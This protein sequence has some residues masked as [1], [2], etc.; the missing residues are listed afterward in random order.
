VGECPK[1]VYMLNTVS[2]NSSQ[3]SVVAI[4]FACDSCS[5][6]DALRFDA[7][8]R[9]NEVLR[10]MRATRAISSAQLR[11]ALAR[12][13]GLHPGR[14]YVSVHPSAFFNWVVRGLRKTYGATGLRSGGLRID[15]TLDS[16]MQQIADGAL[17]KWLTSDTDPSGALVAIDPHSG[18]IRALATIVPGG[19]RLRFNL[20]TQSRRQAGSAF[21]TFTITAA[22]EHGIP[23]NSVWNGP[24]S[25]TIPNPRCFTGI[26]TPW[27][28]H[29]FADETAGTMTLLSALAHSVNTIFAQVALRV[30]P[31][32]IVDVAHRLGVRS[33]LKPV[34]S[35]T[36]GPEGVSPLELTAAFATLAAGG[37]RRDPQ[38][39]RR[40]T[41]AERAVLRLPSGARSRRR[42][43]DRGSGHVR[44]DRGNQGR[45]GRRRRSG[46]SRRRETGTAEHEKD[47]WFCGFVPQLAA[48]VWIGYPHSEQPMTSVDGFPPVVGGSVPTRIWHDFMVAALKGVPVIRFPTVP[49][50][51]LRVSGTRR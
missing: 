42:P 51:Q 3:S 19:R 48:C 41:T 7:L 25:L 43:G 21:K 22:I 40:V 27:T 30:G 11:R 26:N 46:P 10:A 39:V 5:R 9:R 4:R 32:N 50:N 49:A 17:A 2:D 20:A 16:H 15:T 29:N 38:D 37:I 34:C 45:H 8:D 13:L 33:P 24:P 47:A 18:G 31:R 35:I 23:L 1:S 44:V 14:R 6:R 12:P 28:V 36:L